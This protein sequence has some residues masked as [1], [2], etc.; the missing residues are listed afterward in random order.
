MNE[1]NR[2]WRDLIINKIKE[3]PKAKIL[4]YCGLNHSSYINSK[5][6]QS[7]SDLLTKSI[8]KEKVF[9]MNL[10]S[11]CDRDLTSYA[12][13][14]NNLDQQKFII[15]SKDNLHLKYS[16]MQADVIIYQGKSVF[17]QPENI[18]E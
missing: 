13:S 11:N 14:I 8:S 17:C 12:A 16:S 6:V 18:L 5:K 1:R 2:Q 15:Y 10:A 3:D 7:L 9:V 4:V